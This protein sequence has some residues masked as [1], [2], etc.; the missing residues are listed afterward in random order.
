M[1]KNKK[2]KIIHVDHLVIHA[3]NVDIIHEPREREEHR[4]HRESPWDFFWGR[5]RLREESQLE[6]GF[7]KDKD[8]D[9][10]KHK[11]KDK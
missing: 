11:H 8:K 5:P 3:K 6:A 10:H 1:S 4:E 7:D 2:E 9:K